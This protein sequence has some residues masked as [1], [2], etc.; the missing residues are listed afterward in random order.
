MTNEKYTDS[1]WHSVDLNQP[2]DPEQGLSEKE[3]AKR[4]KFLNDLHMQWFDTPLDE[5][6]LPDN[7][8]SN[9]N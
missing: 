9:K 7:L 1:R 2:D 5:Q 4:A 6:D 3:K 8:K